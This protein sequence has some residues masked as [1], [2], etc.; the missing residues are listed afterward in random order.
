M[1]NIRTIL[2]CTCLVAG[3]AQANTAAHSL[4]WGKIN[5]LQFVVDPN[6]PLRNGDVAATEKISPTYGSVGGY[7]FDDL[8][9]VTKQEYS[10]SWTLRYENPNRITLHAEN[11]EPYIKGQL[12]GEVVY[13]ENIA[14]CKRRDEP[15]TVLKTPLRV[16]EPDFDRFPE[17][18]IHVCQI[19]MFSER[20]ITFKD[21]HAIRHHYGEEI[22]FA[23]VAFGRVTSPLKSNVY[24][25]TFHKL[26]AY[27]NPTEERDKDGQLVY[28][29]TYNYRD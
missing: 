15:M 7:T 17:V 1:M 18:P 6:Y 20:V 8:G 29:L 26:D 19:H 16:F 21:N 4:H 22:M 28:K 23:K 2:A 12:F 5:F 11:A 27:G 9:R 3:I 14:D 10:Q 13:V 24:Q 25:R